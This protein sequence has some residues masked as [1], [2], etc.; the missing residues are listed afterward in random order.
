[1]GGIGAPAGRRTEDIDGRDTSRK[2]HDNRHQRETNDYRKDSGFE[3][4]VSGCR[5]S[6]LGRTVVRVRSEGCS[7]F[8]HV[9][10]FSRGFVG[11]SE[12]V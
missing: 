10:C 12:K 11:R 7:W 5:F 2:Y 6:E 3:E 4:L 1:M 8:V 9:K